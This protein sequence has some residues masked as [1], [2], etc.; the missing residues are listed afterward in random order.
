MRTKHF[1]VALTL[2]APTLLA[3]VMDTPARASTGCPAGVAHDLLTR[4][5]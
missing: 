4:D 3:T 2:L 1:L 5:A